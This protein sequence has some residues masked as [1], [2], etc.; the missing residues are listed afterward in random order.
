MLKLTWRGEGVILL[1]GMWERVGQQFWSISYYVAQTL[2]WF[3]ILEIHSTLTPA[4][5]MGFQ[6]QLFPGNRISLQLPKALFNS[7]SFLAWMKYWAKLF[8][9]NEDNW[10]IFIQMKLTCYMVSQPLGYVDGWKL[11]NNV[12]SSVK[13]SRVNKGNDL[14]LN[15]RSGNVVCMYAWPGANIHQDQGI[16]CPCGILNLALIPL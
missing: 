13:V 12:M 8:N 5:F 16:S 2:S 4:V 15:A 3:T 10:F 14:N 1:T 7:C 6:G 11:F 9:F